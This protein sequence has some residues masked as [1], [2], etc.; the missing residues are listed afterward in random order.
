VRPKGFSGVVP[1][2]SGREKECMVLFSCNSY[3]TA[4]CFEVLCA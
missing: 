4:I 2:H 3:A 1:A